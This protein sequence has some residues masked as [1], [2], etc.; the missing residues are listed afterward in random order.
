MPI[1]RFL[2]DTSL[3]GLARRLR[4][5]GYDVTVRGNCRLE[6]LCLAARAAGR[7]V[8]TTSVR[9]PR[10][11]ALVHRLVVP[12]EDLAG[13]VRAVAVEFAADAAPFRRCSRCNGLLEEAPGPESAARASGSI[14]AEARDVSRCSRCGRWYWHGSHV[15]RMRRWFA[16]VLAGASSPGEGPG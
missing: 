14:P 15:D 3:E 4:I 8:I 1:G 11:C 2:V 10:P 7:V 9:V 13:A 6:D 12:R 5:L 16:T